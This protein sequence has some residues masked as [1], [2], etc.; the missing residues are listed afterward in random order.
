MQLLGYENNFQ[1]SILA[2]I[3]GDACDVHNLH[4]TCKG[5]YIQI[6]YPA[7]GYISRIYILWIYILPILGI[8]DGSF[9]LTVCPTSKMWDLGMKILNIPNIDCRESIRLILIR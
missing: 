6:Q 2:Q 1:L 7:I 4:V 9:A 5:L 8:K 3:K